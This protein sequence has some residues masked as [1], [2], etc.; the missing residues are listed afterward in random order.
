MTNANRR[1]GASGERAESWPMWVRLKLAV[2]VLQSAV[3]LVS[4]QEAVPLTVLTNA[5]QV[6]DLGIEGARRAPHPVHLRA[7]VTC[8]V[9]GRPW[10]YAQDATGGILVVCTNLLRPPSA[11]ELVEIFG[12]AGP[13]LSAPHVLKGDFR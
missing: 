10:F 8:P 11:G 2:L 1:R 4:A 5:Q 3:G 12:K 6:L 13:G 9:R 7:V